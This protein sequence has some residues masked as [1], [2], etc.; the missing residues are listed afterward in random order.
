MLGFSIWEKMKTAKIILYVEKETPNIH[1]DILDALQ[2]IDAVSDTFTICG[3][4]ANSILQ[5]KEIKQRLTESRAFVED[6]GSK[7][8]KILDKYDLGEN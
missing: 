6:T 1:L 7:G 2:I 8:V 4:A 3:E 5:L